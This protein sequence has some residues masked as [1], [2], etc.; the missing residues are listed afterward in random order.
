MTL[1]QLAIISIIFLTFVLFIW[2]KFRY[3]V[4]S[5]ISLCVLFIA[6]MILGGEKSDLIVNTSDIFIGFGHMDQQ[7]AYFSKKVFLIFLSKR[8]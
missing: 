4:V 5:I 7:G 3:D 1:D 2:S 8:L 6:D